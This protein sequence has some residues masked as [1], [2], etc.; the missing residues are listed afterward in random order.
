MHPHW[1]ILCKVNPLYKNKK[2]NK[3]KF[4]ISMYLSSF[5]PQCVSTLLDGEIIQAGYDTLRWARVIWKLMK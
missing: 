3:D 5:L 2:N 1:F 4:D